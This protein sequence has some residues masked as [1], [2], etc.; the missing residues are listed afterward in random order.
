MVFKHWLTW[1]K[2]F[3]I[4]HVRKQQV[5]VGSQQVNHLRKSHKCF[6]TYMITSAFE[7]YP[8]PRCTLKTFMKLRQKL[9]DPEQ[10]FVD[11]KNYYPMRNRTR[12]TQQSRKWP[13][14]PLRHPYSPFRS[15]KIWSSIP[16]IKTNLLIISQPYDLH[17]SSLG[18]SKVNYLPKVTRP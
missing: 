15:L 14:K 6:N 7:M 5:R 17:I 12:N 11:H 4:S 13:L 9:L 8:V 3:N 2:T 16:L 18:I 1:N 10:Q